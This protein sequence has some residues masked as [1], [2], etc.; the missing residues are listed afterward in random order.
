MAD[1]SDTSQPWVC[2][3]SLFKRYMFEGVNPQEV[4][5]VSQAARP[6]GRAPTVKMGAT[7]SR[8]LGPWVEQDAESF[9]FAT[10]YSEEEVQDV[11][12]WAQL[13][14][15]NPGMPFE[16]YMPGRNANTTAKMQVKFSPNVVRLDVSTPVLE[17]LSLT[18]KLA[19]ISG[20]A[21]PN[22]A[23]Y[24]LPGVINVAEVVSDVRF[25]GNVYALTHRWIRKMS[26][27]WLIWSRIWS[28]N[29]SGAMIVSIFWLCQ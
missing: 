29:T 9:A 24:D 1:N 2:E 3:V 11:L 26:G 21:L 16:L 13:A 12:Y 20:P 5:E 23:F 22:L 8:P 27:I 19:Q 4:V 6:S 15:L 17:P 14:I 18:A 10:V 28:K 7:R 25:L